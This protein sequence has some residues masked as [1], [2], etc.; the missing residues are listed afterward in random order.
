MKIAVIGAG[1]S[2]I[3]CAHYLSREHDVDMFEASD[4][5][6][7][8]TD[9][10]DVQENGKL[11]R[12]DTGFIVFNE[13]N[14]PNFTNFLNDLNVHSMPTTMSFSVHSVDSGLEYNATDFDGLFCQRKNL[15]KP[16][17][18]AMLK[19]IVRFYKQAP[20]ILD[21]PDD[22]MTL[23][24][25][26]EQHKYSKA[27]IDDHIVPMACAL[28][29]G[30]STSIK[31]FPI[32][33]F[34]RF[35]HNHKM[36]SLT[37]RPLWRVVKHGSKTY[38]EAFLD[39]F[40]GT[41]YT[42]SPV[43]S[44]E[45]NEKSVNIIVN[46]KSFAYEKVVMAI[47]SDQ[48]LSLLSDATDIER[49]VL[50][51]IAYE[52]NHVVLHTD[53]RV[54]PKNRKAWACWNARVSQDLKSNCTVSYHMNQLQSLTT[55]TDYITSLNSKALIDANKIIAERDYMHPV[56]NQNTIESQARWGELV[57]QNNHTYFCGAYWGW[58]F[59]ED[60]VKSGLRVVDALRQHTQG[61]FDVT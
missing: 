38:I 41:V 14:Y 50:G 22:G 58:G 16:R 48:A 57:A 32:R 15:F 29:S 21:T 27:F 35:M 60:G 40:S 44:I 19:D 33:Y 4:Y 61:V 53:T 43:T 30:P 5:V 25:Y 37:E 1:I 45:R 54:M 13:L 2:G 20:A 31:S 46:G 7:G 56:Y 36:L 23:G 17:F 34:V 47:H 55:Q 26:L 59:H 6:G 18:Y 9:T 8:H 39:Q 11:V 52:K 28:W 24:Q 49:D 10:H 12:V 3:T 51:H 42:R